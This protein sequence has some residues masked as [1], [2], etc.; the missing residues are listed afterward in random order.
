MVWFCFSFLLLIVSFSLFSPVVELAQAGPGAGLV[1]AGA[2]RADFQLGHLLCTGSSLPGTRSAPPSLK[3]R[4]TGR[5]ENSF[6]GLAPPAGAGSGSGLLTA[7]PLCRAWLVLNK[8]YLAGREGESEEGRKEG[9]Y[10]LHFFSFLFI[11]V[12]RKKKK[13]KQSICS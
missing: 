2:G 5:S 6:L 11:L 10:Y 12:K 9:R 13:Q 4:W 1:G 8:R 3:S 7:R